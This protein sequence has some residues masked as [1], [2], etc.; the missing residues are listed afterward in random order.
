MITE[1]IPS[2]TL[3]IG[4]LPF[5][6]SATTFSEYQD[7][8]RILNGPPAEHREQLTRSLDGLGAATGRFDLVAAQCDAVLSGSAEVIRGADPGA[9]F[10]RAYGA[11]LAHSLRV[12]TDLEVGPADSLIDM[13]RAKS[14][15]R[16]EKYASGS[17][18]QA[19]TV[20][21]TI[22]GHF[23]DVERF[24]NITGKSL[25]DVLA[26]LREEMAELR[27][28]LDSLS[29]DSQSTRLPLRRRDNLVTWYR[30]KSRAKVE[31]FDPV[32]A[33]K[34]EIADIAIIGA[35]VARFFGPATEAQLQATLDRI[36]LQVNKKHAKHEQRTLN[37][38]K[39]S[40]SPVAA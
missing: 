25:A 19:G 16:D 37:P 21:P 33:V 15:K 22:T 30:E 38:G 13:I 23:S 9:E 29:L 11:Y 8:A 31:K 20:A 24:D 14:V 40:V 5:S 18:S 7:W 10:A 34:G 28:A 32:T 39:P 4:I 12:W 3:E 27:E 6:Q 36:Q 17:A 1:E 2:N 26:K 35:S